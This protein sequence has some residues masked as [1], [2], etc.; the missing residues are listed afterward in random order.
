[1]KL[2]ALLILATMTAV[3]ASP[4]TNLN[5]DLDPRS[6][7]PNQLEARAAKCQMPSNC[8][9]GGTIDNSICKGYC[10][11][12]GNGFRLLETQLCPLTNHGRYFRCCCTR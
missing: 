6:E 2:S 12:L 1:M 4:L 8:L 5:T 3:H 7:D 10:S 9:I 11:R